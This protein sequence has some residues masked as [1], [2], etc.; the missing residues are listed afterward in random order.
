[1]TD[2]QLI[3][4]CLRLERA[5]QFE[6]VQRFGPRLL[7]VCRRYTPAGQ[8][9]RD[10]LQDAFV[11]VFRNLDRY[12]P[13]RGPLWPW[14][15]TVAIRETLKKHRRKASLVFDDLEKEDGMVSLPDPISWQGLEAEYLLSLIARLPDGH[16]NVFNLVAIEGYSHEECAS[17]L[18]IS[19]GTSRSALSRARRQLQLQYPKIIQP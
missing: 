11:L 6:L 15:K 7:T 13:Q 1:M 19:P 5:A 18:G 14:I 4:A 9:A 10:S 2:H 8:D 17:L 12:D 3:E 16:R